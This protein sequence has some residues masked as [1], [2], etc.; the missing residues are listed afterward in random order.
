MNLFD[1]ALSLLDKN[2]IDD[3][4]IIKLKIIQEGTKSLLVSEEKKEDKVK[5]ESIVSKK[6][7]PNIDND[8]KWSL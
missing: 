2:N 1:R 7:L 4:K 8:I 6:E 5:S 3:V